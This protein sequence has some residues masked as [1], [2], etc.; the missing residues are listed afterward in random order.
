MTATP[1]FYRIGPPINDLDEVRR[2]HQRQVVGTPDDREIV[3]CRTCYIFEEPWPC[4]VARLVAIV[5]E[6]IAADR[7]AQD[8][9]ALS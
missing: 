6:Q 7:A 8:A 4:A 5:D 3:T 2:D 1:I 9:K